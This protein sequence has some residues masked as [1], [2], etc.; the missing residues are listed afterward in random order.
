MKLCFYCK[1]P[2]I[3]DGNR[4]Q[5]KSLLKEQ[6]KSQ[7]QHKEEQQQIQENGGHLIIC[8]CGNHFYTLF[9][10]PTTPPSDEC[11]YCNKCIIQFK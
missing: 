3:L 2:I 1:E 7:R 6:K 9:P 11:P 5:H 4:I 10:I 8:C